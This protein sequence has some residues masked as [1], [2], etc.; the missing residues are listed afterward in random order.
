MRDLITIKL[1]CDKQTIIKT[2][3]SCKLFQI[4]FKT[5]E[6]WFGI[7]KI[8]WNSESDLLCFFFVAASVL[9]NFK[10]RSGPRWAPWPPESIKRG[11]NPTQN[12][13]LKCKWNSLRQRR[14]V[15]CL[16]YAESIGMC[17][18]NFISPIKNDYKTIRDIYVT[19][20]S[21]DNCFSWK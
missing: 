14:F 13:R 4:R 16:K 8:K 5:S 2:L 7:E 17:V 18:K 10:T 9:V 1:D 19:T 12:L 6:S 3:V 11:R 20:S 15:A 21:H